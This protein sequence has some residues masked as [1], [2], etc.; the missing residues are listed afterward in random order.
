M[1]LSQ[2]RNEVIASNIANADT[3][4]FKAGE[5]DFSGELEKAF[6]ASRDSSILK[7]NSNHL[8]ISSNDGSAHIEE[9]ISGAMKADGNNVDIDIQMGQLSQN[10]GRYTSAATLIRKQLGIIKLAI[11][12]GAR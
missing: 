3:P 1:D 6:G 9:D 2:R 7:T 8:D 5:L 12:E 10:A 4:G 11:R